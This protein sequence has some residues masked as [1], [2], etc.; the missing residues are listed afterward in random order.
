MVIGCT[1]S[2]STVSRTVVPACCGANARLDRETARTAPQ[3]DRNSDRK[4]INRNREG[5]RN[6]TSDRETETEALTMVM[7]GLWT[8]PL[9]TM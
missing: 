6:G 4:T 1:G 9:L 8:V 3:G 5:Q 2:V 7:G